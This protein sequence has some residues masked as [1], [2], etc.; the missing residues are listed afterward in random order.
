[1][2][3]FILIF[4]Q[5]LTLIGVC[6]VSFLVFVCCY[7]YAEDLGVLGVFDRKLVWLVAI[8]LIGFV[9]AC[10][11]YGFG[12]ALALHLGNFVL[13]LIHVFGI[14]VVWMT[15]VLLTELEYH[16]GKQDV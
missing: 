2:L 4:I 12:M 6:F 5:M 3:V 9:F 16:W 14:K 15:L 11:V 10:K 1:M 8:M 13:I 7:V